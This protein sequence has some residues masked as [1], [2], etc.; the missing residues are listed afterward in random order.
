[1]KS[2][3]R[4][5]IDPA[6]QTFFANLF[7][8]IADE[9]GVTLSRTAYSPNIKE[10]RDSS[11]ALFDAKGG[12][13]AQAAHIPVH[14]GAMPMS[15]HAAL[16]AFDRFEKGDV[17]ALNDPYAGGTH[18]PDITLVTPVIVKGRLFAFLATRAHHADVG[19]MSPGSM[20]LSREIYQEGL[21]I[22]PIK[23]VERGKWNQAVL[24]M[25]KMNVRTPEERMGDLRAQVAAHDVGEA[26]LMESVQKYGQGLI[27]HQMHALIRYGERLMKSVIRQIPNGVYAFHDFLEDD[28][29]SE[30]PI[31]I[32]VKIKIKG[33]QAVVDFTGS[34]PE[35]EGS[36]NSVDAVTAS[37]VYY[38][39]LCLLATPSPL[40][41]ITTDPPLNAGCFAPVKIHMPQ[42][43]IVNARPP[44]AVA[45]GNVETSQRIVDVVFGALAKAI[46]FLI[47]ASSQGTM[48]NLTLGG[49]DAR[50][51]KAFAYYETVGGGMGARPVKDGVDGVQVH[52]TNTMNTPVEALEFAYPLRVERYEFAQNTGGKGKFRGGDGIQRDLRVLCDAQGAILTE[53]RKLAP[54]GLKGGG[55][56]Q[57]GKNVLIRKNKKIKL[58]GKTQLDLKKDDVVSMRTPGA[59]GFGKRR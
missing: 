19:G 41:S 39:F 7:A 27:Q 21:R 10:R 51:G 53:R 56:G 8:S 24:E 35:C 16:K 42:G 9:M 34:D 33:D 6:E 12:L 55:A 50:Y 29:I 14:L 23:L 26:R 46:P 11:C 44:R 2:K 45:G 58:P 31:K 25:L 15:V 4:R 49:Y 47:P 48:N 37:A 5:K 43:S 54:P 52:M 28:G 13:V 22:P 30:R 17:I 36:V 38:C 40:Q 57:C 18:L 1:V 32:A 20:P 3:K 59:G